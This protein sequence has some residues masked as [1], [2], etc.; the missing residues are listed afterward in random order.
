MKTK[1]ISADNY[2]KSSIVGGGF[3]YIDYAVMMTMMVVAFSIIQEHLLIYLKLKENKMET[4]AHGKQ[5]L[6]IN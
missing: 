4:H 2:G 5:K 1:I 3:N 6:H